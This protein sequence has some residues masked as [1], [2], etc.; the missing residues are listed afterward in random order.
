MPNFRRR[1]TKKA[2][3]LNDDQIVKV[4]KYKITIYNPDGTLAN[5]KIEYLP[6][7][8]MALSK[9]GYKHFM[10]KE[11][12]EQPDVVRNI[13]QDKLKNEIDKIV[14]DDIKLNCEQLKN[15]NRI[16]IIACGT[17]FHAG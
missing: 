7:E 9:M 5:N 17:S 13:L 10:L 8:P 16:Q 1:H 2:I 3:Y 12:H 11:I 14:L 4:T 6:F 15:I